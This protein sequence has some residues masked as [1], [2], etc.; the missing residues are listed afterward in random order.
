MYLRKF[1][2]EGAREYIEKM[3]YEAKINRQ[4]HSSVS[5]SNRKTP[6][7]LK[8]FDCGLKI[9][10]QREFGKGPLLQNNNICG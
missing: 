6:V 1:N 9:L 3:V 8:I 10:I 4:T 2:Q 7:K 5:A